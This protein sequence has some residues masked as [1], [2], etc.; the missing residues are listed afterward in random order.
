MQIKR[1][2]ED[3]SRVSWAG[4]AHEIRQLLS[5]LLEKLAPDQ[6]VT[7]QLWYKQDPG[8]AQPTRKQRVRYI[9]EMHKAGSK[10]QAVA[11]T[12]ADLDERIAALVT[13]TYSRGSDA[14]HRYK[15]GSEVKRIL[16]YFEA[17]AQDLLNLE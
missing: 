9:L 14:A 11:D 13:E 6:F 3:T 5:T 10:E 8:T 17:F 12:V 7:T 16:G 2:V 4:T 15:P 1:D